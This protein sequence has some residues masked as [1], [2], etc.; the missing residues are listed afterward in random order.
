MTKIQHTVSIE[1]EGQRLDQLVSTLTGVS[2]SQ[3]QNAIS[4]KQIKVNKAAAKKNGVRVS[5]GDRIEGQIRMPDHRVQAEDI[6]LEIISENDD[7][8]VINKDPGIVVHPDESG[9]AAGTLLNALV[10]H[11]QLSDGSSKERPGI[12]HRLDKDT[13]GVMIVAKNNKTHEILAKAFHDREV[14]KYYLALVKGRMK[15]NSGRI[16]AALR[17][18]TKNRTKM[19]I[20]SQG[21]NAVTHFEVM[22][23]FDGCSLLKIKIETGRTH[24]IRVH[25][26]SIGHPVVCDSVYGDENYNAEFLKE[27]GLKRQFLHS[28][29]LHILGNAYIGGLKKDLLEVLEKLRS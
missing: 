27:F 13:S 19:A 24:Q 28:K 16:E 22:E 15:S 8:I 21:K 11:T 23:D 14:D 5:E 10:A 9:H 2:R 20:H 4:A 7:F 1:E 26:A 6:P 25:M 29:E 3:V 17:R 12:V 18:S